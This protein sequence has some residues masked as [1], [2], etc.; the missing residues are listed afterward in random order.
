MMVK[1]KHKLNLQIFLFTLSRTVVNTNFRMVYPFLPVFARGMG[2][3]PASLAMALSIRSFLGIFGPFLATVADTRDR[4]TGLLL[5]IGLFTLGSALT[6]I[7]PGFI[8]FIIGMSLVILGNGVFIPSINAFIGDR[9]PYEKRGRALAITELSWA[10][11]FIGGIP[12][13]RALI[14]N[15]SWVTPFMLFASVGFILFVILWS[16]LPA[17]RIEKSEGNTL[18]QNLWR[19]VSY[20]PALAGLLM[21]ILFTSANETINLIF[22]LWIEDQFGLNFAALTAASVV[23]GVSELGGEAVT[24]FGMDK[25]GKRRLIW[26]SLLLN[27]LAALIL[28]LTNH[29]LILA[30][31]GLGFFYITFETVLV[32]GLTLMS[33]VV[34]SSRATMIAATV[35]GFSLGRML[36]DLIAPNLYEIS[37]WACA[38]TAA[39]LNV[40][41]MILLKQVKIKPDP[42]PAS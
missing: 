16:V 24:F 2:V 31:V 19:V 1:S 8:T 29:T 9:I 27:S 32:S 39:A 17:Q 14:E 26:V 35:A 36:G 15:F 13:I 34:P 42:T 23:I 5:G 38:L 3:E 41:S 7:W 18:W 21:G 40:I 33:E 11:A 25:I 22:G 30:M 6:A 37:F 28:P 20:W 10:L 4:K 12:L